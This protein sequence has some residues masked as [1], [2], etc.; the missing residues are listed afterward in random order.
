MFVI[1]A[2]QRW[3]QEKQKFMVI[4]Q[5]YLGFH[6]TLS[7]SHIPKTVKKKIINVLVRIS[8][9]VKRHHDHSNAYK[10]KI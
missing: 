9:A 8:I 2:L 6:E 1:L 3:R 5:G 4:L 7:P 10:E